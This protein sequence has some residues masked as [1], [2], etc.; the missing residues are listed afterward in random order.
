MSCRR[1]AFCVEQVLC[2]SCK[3]LDLIVLLFVVDSA[4]A[5]PRPCVWCST[6]V[7]LATDFA[8]THICICICMYTYIHIYIYIYVYIH[9][10]IYVYVYVYIHTC[11]YT[12]M[13]MSHPLEGDEGPG[14][15]NV[16]PVAGYAPLLMAIII[17]SYYH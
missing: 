15:P 9:I 11:T 8:Y 2:C 16:P 4:R 17:N 5:A 13:Y 10:Y 3:C 6:L 12:Y 7:V 1:H 14:Q